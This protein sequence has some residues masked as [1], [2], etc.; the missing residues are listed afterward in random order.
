MMLMSASLNILKTKL[1]I[2]THIGEK[3]KIVVLYLAI[4]KVLQSTRIEL[5]IAYNFAPFC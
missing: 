2:I 4:A 5:Y 3:F 1:Q